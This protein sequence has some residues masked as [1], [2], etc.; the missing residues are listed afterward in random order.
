MMSDFAARTKPLLPIATGIVAVLAATPARADDPSGVVSF[1]YLHSFVFEPQT[2]AGNGVEATFVY[3]D[4]NMP[5][6][7]LG[8]GGFVQLQNMTPT[9]LAFDIGPQANLGPLGFELGYAYRGA[10]EGYAGMHGVRFGP[11]LSVGLLS[12]GVHAA[13]PVGASGAGQAQ[14]AEIAATVALKLFFPVF[15]E[16]YD[17]RFG[18]GL[19]LREGAEAR[20]ASA[21]ASSE[22]LVRTEA[23]TDPTLSDSLREWLA[24]RW[25]ADALDEHAAVAAFAR[26][27]LAL[28]GVGAPASLVE[29]AQRASLDEIRH[30]ERCFGLARSYS[31]TQTGPDRLPGALSPIE[32]RSLEQIAVASLRDGC[33]GEGFGAALAAQACEHT[34]D[35]ELRA[36]HAEIARDESAH[37]ELAW[38]IV[39]WC[40][41]QGGVSVLGA[42]AEA[43]ARLPRLFECVAV[44]STVSLDE[45]R[46]Y[47]RFGPVEQAQIFLRVRQRVRAR[48][49]EV[50]RAP[51][52][53]L[54][55]IEPAQDAPQQC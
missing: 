10:Y 28:L 50:L 45:A 33:L 5:D 30:A 32:L 38:Q 52:L 55:S 49:A 12:L 34:I 24:E 54:R 20:V 11:F 4:E 41:G 27:S 35:P 17:M 48:L 19:P 40:I 8:W 29:A 26:L 7:M 47:G 18:H 39:E 13:V 36:V 21:R 23:T 3:Y 44:P 16:L 6:N 53:Y 31:N 51:R 37:A 25:L 1:G 42:L 9:H 2:S 46:D 15:G 43:D 14:D 22:W